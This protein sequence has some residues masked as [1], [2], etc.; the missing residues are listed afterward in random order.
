MAWQI[1][2]INQKNL[3]DEKKVSFLK[4]R[5]K[6]NTNTRVHESLSLKACKRCI[7]HILVTVIEIVA[8]FDIIVLFSW[9]ASQFLLPA[10]KKIIHTLV[11]PFSKSPSIFICID[12]TSLVSFSRK[13]WLID[14]KA[15]QLL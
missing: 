14:F 9:I 7:L 8:I 4:E 10:I 1:V 2:K 13:Q 6:L 11:G 5:R 12:I 15:Y 3:F